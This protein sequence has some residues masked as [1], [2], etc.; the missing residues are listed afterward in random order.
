MKQRETRRQFW[1]A[2]MTRFEGSGKS[3]RDFASEA[4]VGLAIFQYWLY[5]IRRERGAKTGRAA[6]VPEVRLVPITVRASAVR[7]PRSKSANGRVLRKE[8]LGGML[9]YYHRKAA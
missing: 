4:G 1:M 3:R 8:R 2:L 6:S 5:K 9:N 7:R